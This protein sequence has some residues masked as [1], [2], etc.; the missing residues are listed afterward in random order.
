MNKVY[1]KFLALFSIGLFITGIISTTIIFYIPSTGI[2]YD[3]KYEKQFNKLIFTVEASDHMYCVQFRDN[4]TRAPS[5]YIDCFNY[6]HD[7]SFSYNLTNAEF[8]TE[9]IMEVVL[10]GV[11]ADY[12]IIQAKYQFP[13]V[14][15]RNIIVM[16]ENDFITLDISDNVVLQ[17]KYL[18]SESKIAILT[19]SLNYFQVE[20]GFYLFDVSGDLIGTEIIDLGEY[21]YFP[22]NNVELKLPTYVNKEYI[23]GY[24]NDSWDYSWYYDL[25]VEQVTDFSIFNYLHIA[26]LLWFYGY[27]TTSRGT[28]YLFR[29]F[30]FVDME[31]WLESELITKWSD[32]EF[33]HYDPLKLEIDRS[34]ILGFEFSNRFYFN[35]MY[36]TIGTG[37]LDGLYQIDLNDGSIDH[38]VQTNYDVMTKPIVVGETFLIS[39]S[40]ILFES[41]VSYRSGVM[42]IYPSFDMFKSI[43]QIPNF[44]FYLIPMIL[45]TPAFLFLNRDLLKNQYRGGLSLYPSLKNDKK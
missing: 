15:I 38:I 36:S 19:L 32:T 29:S 25:H 3:N 40:S 7:L 37:E 17:Q 34:L 4:D 33:R 5:L 26:S 12:I 14:P 2:N 11:I 16:H 30:D 18:I 42:I 10:I 28:Y 31:F 23:F 44:V 41:I 21:E 9:T 22:V 27:F 1:I 39:G 20:L 24:F 13:G 8:S 43:N 6:S 45:F 35:F